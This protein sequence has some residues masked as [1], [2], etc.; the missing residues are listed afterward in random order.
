MSRNPFKCRKK[1]IQ[2]VT[3]TS[4]TN[5]KFIYALNFAPLLKAFKIERHVNESKDSRDTF[6][7]YVSMNNIL[8]LYLL[9]IIL[10]ML[11]YLYNYV[12]RKKKTLS[13]RG[14]KI[15]YF[16]ID[17]YIYIITLSKIAYNI[18]TN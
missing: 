11:Q 6:M 15:I 14:S 8:L 2:R 3:I 1:Q 12:S 18:E 7:Y 5:R 4:S 16:I 13:V 17:I 9:I 10:K